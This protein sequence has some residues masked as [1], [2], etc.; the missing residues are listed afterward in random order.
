M[1]CTLVANPSTGKSARLKMFKK[2]IREIKTFDQIPFEETKLIKCKNKML[3]FLT[4]LNYPLSNRCQR[5]SRY[6]SFK[7]TEL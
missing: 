1:F 7:S 5:R 2:S 6:F 4:F 3:H